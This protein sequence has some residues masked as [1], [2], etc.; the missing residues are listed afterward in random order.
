MFVNSKVL[1]KDLLSI[2]KTG[3]ITK[4]VVPKSKVLTSNPTV[5]KLYI[6]GELV[7][8][9]QLEYQN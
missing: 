1:V 6:G 4:V 2:E 5:A 8:P 3:H 9:S 7:S